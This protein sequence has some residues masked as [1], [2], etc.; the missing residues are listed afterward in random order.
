[1]E[2]NDGSGTDAKIHPRSVPPAMGTFK[3]LMMMLYS[4]NKLTASG[5]DS[6]EHVAGYK[7]LLQFP[8]EELERAGQHVNV[9]AALNHG[10]VVLIDLKL[11]NVFK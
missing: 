3:R 10:R 6:V 1:M 11:Y 2:V 4:G 7:W 5:E 8:E 9:R